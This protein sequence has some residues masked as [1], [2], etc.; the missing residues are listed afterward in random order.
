MSC[1]TQPPI[2]SYLS[3]H[4][5]P[6]FKTSFSSILIINRSSK[7]NCQ[8]F[9]FLRLSNLRFKTPRGHQNPPTSLLLR[10]P[11][12]PTP[13]TVLSEFA[14]QIL[15]S[16]AGGAFSLSL[17][18]H[19]VPTTHTHTHTPLTFVT[20]TPTTLSSYQLGLLSKERYNAPHVIRSTR[21]A[22]CWP[23]KAES[24]HVTVTNH[25]SIYTYHAL[26]STAAHHLT[27]A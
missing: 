4:P 21:F 3:L 22:V 18:L 14:S 17:A 2:L 7:E 1:F 24:S 25:K 19:L 27:T 12:P 5:L 11:L 23:H 8:R 16:Q 26:G 10:D 9:L 13:C 20:P 15:A 6:K